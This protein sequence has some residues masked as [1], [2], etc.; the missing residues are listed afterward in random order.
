MLNFARGKQHL[1]GFIALADECMADYDLNGWTL[2]Y[3][4][5]RRGA[6]TGIDAEP[7]RCRKGTRDEGR[8]NR[9]EREDARR[10]KKEL[11]VNE[12]RWSGT[13]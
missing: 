1:A 3:L 13:R 2:G 11:I 7:Q 6:I 9:R 4:G 8:I 5:V 12:K 10:T